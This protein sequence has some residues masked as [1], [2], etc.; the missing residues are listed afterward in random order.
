MSHRQPWVL[1]GVM[2][3][4]LVALVGCS[5]SRP[6]PA[7]RHFSLQAARQTEQAATSADRTLRVRE[8]HVAPPF[9]RGVFV[10]QVGESEFKQ[11]YYHEFIVPPAELITAQ[12][13]AWLRGS[14]V[15]SEVLNG[16]SAADEDFVLEG[17]VTALH[18]DYRDAASPRAVLEIQMF[19]LAEEGGRT[20]VLFDKTYR[21]ETAVAG[22]DPADLVHGWNQ[23]LQEILGNLEQDLRSCPIFRSASGP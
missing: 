8:F 17:T 5:L 19:L 13:I 15:F 3:G 11:D 9:H 6:Y 4:V 18:G 14:G 23:G 2:S 10:Y 20:S 22:E 1:S 21:T 7:K 16:R 12:A